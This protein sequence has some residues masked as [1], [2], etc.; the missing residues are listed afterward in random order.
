MNKFSQKA[1]SDNS[2]LLKTTKDTAIFE[3][4]SFTGLPEKHIK[5]LYESDN[6]DSFKDYIGFTGNMEHNVIP[7]TFSITNEIQNIL[8]SN[9]LKDAK[10]KELN[11]LTTNA[12]NYVNLDSVDLLTGISELLI[13]TDSKAKDFILGKNKLHEFETTKLNESI[14]LFS[15]KN[16]FTNSEDTKDLFENL[17]DLLN[18]QNKRWGN[19]YR[20]SNTYQG[21]MYYLEGEI[22]RLMLMNDMV[23]TDS[24][25]HLDI[26][27]SFINDENNPI[28]RNFSSIKT[29]CADVQTLDFDLI[30][31]IHHFILCNNEALQFISRNV[32]NEYNKIANTLISEISSSVYSSKILTD[33]IKT[34]LTNIFTDKDKTIYNENSPLIYTLT[35]NIDF[36]KFN[37]VNVQ[38]SISVKAAHDMCLLLNSTSI[39]FN[40]KLRPMIKNYFTKAF[41][42][43]K[44]VD[45]AKFKLNKHKFGN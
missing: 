12:K 23:T 27:Q 32:L 3:A 2:N 20:L 30:L 1:L 24:K 14:Q 4:V 6:L 35:N 28:Y 45:E 37:S 29:L 8:N 10:T 9:D 15:N 42:L 13:V 34:E 25:I 43:I 18:K 21:I 33:N 11:R 38:S 22:Q 40:L 19:S 39:E 7:K 16:I 41:E 5:L 36:S 44:R 26:I 31:L 17:K